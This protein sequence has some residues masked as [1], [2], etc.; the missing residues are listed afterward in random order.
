MPTFQTSGPID[1][2]VDLQAGRLEVI[3]T[4]R[5]D[6]VV[7]VSPDNP[8]KALDRKAAEAT[9]VEFDGSRLTVAGPR[10]FSL[11]GPFESIA[12]RVEV[13]TGSR[14]TADVSW[15]PVRATGTF[16]ATRIK[17]SGSPIELG[18]TGD[19]WVNAGH[20]NFEV[21]SVA[22][23]LEVSAAHGNIRV[24]SVTGDARLKASHGSVTVGE[25]GGDVDANLAYGEFEVD[26]VLG[27]VTAK[28]AYGSIRL[29]EVSN[30]S[31]RVE[32]GY[33]SVQIGIKPG[34]AAW[35]DLVSKNGRVRNELDAQ[36]APEVAD[37]SVDIRART[38]A[39]DITIQRSK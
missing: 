27:S 32:S 12:V 35:L 36:S 31:I 9:K 5:T 17:A 30:G 38:Q 11:I 13:P 1:L 3:A 18:D 4:D 23:S 14:L 29:G 21:G 7:T 20:G 26:R 28:T 15:G 10:R 2:A 19:L 6:I 25:A 33:G 8:D 39:S 34:V 37:Q 22:G 24:G 16:G